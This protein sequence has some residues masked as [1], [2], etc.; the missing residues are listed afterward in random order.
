DLP[1]Q[2]KKLVIDTAGIV[3]LGKVIAQHYLSE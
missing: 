2:E 3:E 1:P